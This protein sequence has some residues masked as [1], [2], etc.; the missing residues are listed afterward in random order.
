MEQD[1]DLAQAR[2]FVELL[3]RRARMLVR[4]IESAQRRDP[5]ARHELFSELCVVRG[6]ID[7]LHRR[8]PQLAHPQPASVPVARRTPG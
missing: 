3:T 4:D 1:A 2:V 5:A 6:Y 8:F 7:R